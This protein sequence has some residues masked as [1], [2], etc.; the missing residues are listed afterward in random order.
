MPM[1]PRTMRNGRGFS[2]LVEVLLQNKTDADMS[3][4]RGVMDELSDRAKARGL[5]PEILEA[6]LHGR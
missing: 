6:I 4:L 3:L 2:F 1:K 5:T